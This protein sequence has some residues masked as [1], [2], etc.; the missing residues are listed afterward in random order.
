MK[1]TGNVTFN[2]LRKVR[3]VLNKANIKMSSEH[4]IRA[5]KETNSVIKRLT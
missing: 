1:I 2:G 5:L 4:K 3:S